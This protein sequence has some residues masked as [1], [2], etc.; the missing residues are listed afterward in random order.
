MAKLV[1][2]HVPSDAAVLASRHA[3][4]FPV[5]SLSS[6]A[7]VSFLHL[8][9]G[10]RAEPELRGDYAYAWLVEGQ[11]AIGGLPCGGGDAVALQGEALFTIAAESAC[12]CLVVESLAKS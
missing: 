6:P 11:A 1:S 5:L 4:D 3:A 9:A 7:A 10:E 2:A 8:K 12:K